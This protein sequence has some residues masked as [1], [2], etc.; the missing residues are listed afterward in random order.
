MDQDIWN[1]LNSVYKFVWYKH[2]RDN[3]QDKIILALPEKFKTSLK[4]AKNEKEAKKIIK[5]FLLQGLEGRKIKYLK[6]AKDLKKAWKEKGPTIEN[7]LQKIYGKEFPF[8]TVKV[9]LSSLPICP[10][11]F[12]KRWIMIFAGA[13]TEKQIKILTHELNHFMF[14]YYFDGLKKEL[15]EEKFESLKEALT[16]FTNPEEKGYPNQKRLR[17]WLA[18]QNKSITEIIESGEWKDHF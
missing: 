17:A 13:S 2:G 11:N 9:F 15:D 5:N 10:Y 1:Y 4:N 14:Y 16:V 7:K 3:I 8:K 6:V 18:T 12:K